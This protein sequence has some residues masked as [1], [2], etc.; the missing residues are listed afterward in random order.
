MSEKLIDIIDFRKSVPYDPNSGPIECHILSATSVRDCRY[1]ELPCFECPLAQRVRKFAELPFTIA[2]TPYDLIEHRLRYGNGDNLLRTELG[3]QTMALKIG[4]VLATGERLISNPR[5][6]YNG[7]V[8]LHFNGRFTGIPSRIPIAFQTP[9][10]LPAD[11][12][13]GNTLLTED[14]VLSDPKSGED[15]E[16]W[17]LLTGGF[18]GHLISVPKNIPIALYP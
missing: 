8:W 4:D 15:G 3:A 12:K 18:T 14:K 13:A 16:V 7:T 2:K 10:A 6:G 1:P 9:F 11:L 17:L 5:T